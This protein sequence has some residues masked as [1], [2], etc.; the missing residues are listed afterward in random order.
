[1]LCLLA[2]LY[3][4]HLIRM[5]IPLPYRS[6][7]TNIGFPNHRF[8]ENLAAVNIYLEKQLPNETA[9]VY[10]RQFD[11]Y[12]VVAFSN[13]YEKLTYERHREICHIAIKKLEE[14]RHNTKFDDK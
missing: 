1:M 10:P 12:E 8:V 6:S 13:N 5:L 4:L 9:F 14:V 11:E 3:K 2:M 7:F